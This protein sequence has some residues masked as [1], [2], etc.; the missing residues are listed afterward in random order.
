MYAKY[1]D[2]IVRLSDTAWIPQEPMNTD[3]AE[4]LAY[5]EVNDLTMDDILEYEI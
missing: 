1:E 2:M 4:F 3:Y 5:L